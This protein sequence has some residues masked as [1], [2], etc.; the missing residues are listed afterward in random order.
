MRQL[1]IHIQVEDTTYCNLN[2]KTCDR[3]EHIT[4]PQ[5]LNLEH[6]KR[7]VMQIHPKKISLSGNGEPFLHPNMIEMISLAKEQGCS[8]DITTNGTLITSERCDQIVKSGLDLIK[9]SLD[10]VTRETYQTVRGTDKF[11]QILDGIH[12]LVETKKR[13]NSLTPFIRLNYVITNHN[14]R[15]ITKIVEL[16]DKLSVD[17]VFFQV[18]DLLDIENRQ[19][20]LV[21]DLT[22][23]DFSQTITQALVISQKMKVNT[24]LRSI[25]KERSTYWKKYQGEQPYQQ[26]KRVCILPWFHTYISVDGDVRPCCYFKY[27]QYGNMGNIFESSIEEIW[28]DTMY[29]NFR[30]AM[31]QGKRPSPACKQCMSRTFSDIIANLLFAKVI[32]RFFKGFIH[33]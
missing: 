11:L 2:C 5:H 6:F 14:Y 9:I 8:V 4:R 12:A 10:G 28:N 1:P 33:H 32:S 29:Q 19:E 22:Y 24:N 23:E 17:G 15:E 30:K 20:S 26:K 16:A 7:I 3:A 25:H 27:G 13:L 21:G 18:L 31:R